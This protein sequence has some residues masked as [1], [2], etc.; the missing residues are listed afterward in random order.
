MVIDR[1]QLI[2]GAAACA[3]AGLTPPAA[4]AAPLIATL[5]RDASQYGVRPNSPDDQTKALQRAIDDAARAQI[6]LALPPG[7]YRTGLLSLPNGAQLIGVRGATR[8]LFNGGRSLLE[9]QGGNAVELSGLT[10]DGAQIR[11]PPRRG[12]VHCQ[13][14]RELRIAQCT[15]A[16]SGGSGIWLDNIAG[17]ISDN[18]FSNIAVTAVVSFDAQNL[19]VARNAIVGT[20][21]NGIEI[22]RS[23]TGDDGTQVLD[24]R[25]EDIKAGPGGS[26]QYGNAINAFRAG[27]VIVRGNRIRNC[28]YSAVRGNSAANIQITGNS[29]SNVR[30]VALYSEFSFEGA[31][32]ANNT[33]DGAA[34]GV[35]VCNFNEGGRLSVVQGN[36][37]RNLKPK[38]PIGTAP[39]DD[40]GI[41]IY[42]EADTAV[43]G[44]VVENAPAFGIVAGWG[45]YLR[46]VAISGNVIRNAFVGIGVSV[47][48]GAGT[49]LV[50]NNVI[51]GTPRGA[52]VGLDHARP[53]T[54]D[55]A[56]P[57]A[58]KFAQVVIGSNAAR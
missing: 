46:D 14:G 37:I 2:T 30:E 27:N 3:A 34:V 43:T 56:A 36:L 51:S 7:V 8:L 26:G 50:G 48:D 17:D 47:A 5:G 10:L 22:L 29:V 38:R 54:P 20:N 25:I 11:L 40:A 55:L 18:S 4:R 58:A 16:N 35:S 44:N 13:Q 6:P 42:V 49:A 41:G 39:D 19:V 15:I 31:V 9:S 45:N 21:D 57:G 52:V 12:L 24:N 33:V 23:A 53:V 1:R 32:I 28:D